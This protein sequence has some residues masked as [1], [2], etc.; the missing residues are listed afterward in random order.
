MKIFNTA[1]LV[2]LALLLSCTNSA[3]KELAGGTSEENNTL[4]YNEVLP[5]I[6]K[7]GHSKTALSFKSQNSYAV[8]IKA[9]DKFS[10]AVSFEISAW[11]RIDS[12]PPK[13][14]QPYNLIGKF[15]ADSSALPSEFSLALVN[16]ACGTEVPS[17]AFFLTEGSSLFACKDAVLSKNP[18][19]ADLWTFV[20]IKWD[21]RYLTLHQDG[22]AVAKEERILAVLPYSNLP[23]YL[24]K[25]KI[26]FAIDK[27]SLN[28]EA[29]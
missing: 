10:A 13:S 22:I 9:G 5:T 4:A 19:K 28:S 29:L 26:P 8:S 27:L 3:K 18:V 2:L 6:G 20:E 14:E 7:D 15:K 17:F 11:F 16:G 12:L 25:S 23:I 1:L 21:G 24:G